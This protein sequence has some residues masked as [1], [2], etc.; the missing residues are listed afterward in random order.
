MI[1]NCII[2]GK[3]FEAVKSFGKFP[4][5]CGTECFKIN[6]RNNARKHYE[7]KKE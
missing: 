3:E 4:M 5:T 1:K 7:N 2:C 6:R